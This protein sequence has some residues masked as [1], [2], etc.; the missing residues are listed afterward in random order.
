MITVI[1]EFPEPVTEG[2]LKLAFALDGRPDAL[3]VTVL[4]NPFWEVTVTV[5][6]PW[7]PCVS[8]SEVGLAEIEKVGA[9]TVNITLVEWLNELPAPVIVSV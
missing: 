7:L 4:L 3:N 6:V 8:V 1:V 5:E 9:V 2:G